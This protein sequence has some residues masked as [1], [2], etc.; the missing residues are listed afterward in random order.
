MDLFNYSILDAGDRAIVVEFGDTIDRRV[1][2]CVN[3]LDRAVSAAALPGVIEAVPTFRSLM[4]HF[5]PLVMERAYLIA[6]IAILSSR[7]NPHQ[8][9]GRRWTLP[10]CYAPD[11][12]PDLDAVS[13]ATGISV[14]DVIEL[15][16]T[17]RYH[18]YMLGFLP[19]QP[20]LGDNPTILS[21]PRRPIPRP[22]VP[23]GSV[24]IAMSMSTIFP[25]DTPSGW[26]V[27]GRCPITMWDETVMS[28]PLLRTT[29]EIRFKPVSVQDF[30][31]LRAEAIE[32][33]VQLSPE[34]LHD[35]SAG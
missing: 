24:G 30:H 11:M 26:H 21:L 16:C 13:A 32:G 8:D 5:D 10:V 15:H 12:A 14:D 1:N 18:V 29:D 19:G 28:A 2:A 23:G 3:A 34:L 17:T 27:I 33:R 7:L 31:R 9:V 6:Q 22:A 4:I 20:Y 25:R 35:A